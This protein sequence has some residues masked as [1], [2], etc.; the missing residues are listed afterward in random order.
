MAEEMSL[1]TVP[2]N[3]THVD[4]TSPRFTCH[5]DPSGGCGLLLQT[6]LCDGEAVGMLKGLHSTVL[7]AGDG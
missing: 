4:A 6:K 3:C 7:D 5:Q 2:R 1:N